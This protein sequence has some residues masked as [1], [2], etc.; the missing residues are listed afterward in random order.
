M[1]IARLL[2]LGGALLHL[3]LFGYVAAARFRYPWELDWLSGAILDHI[4]RLH[5]GLAQ[6]YTAPSVNWISYPYPPLHYWVSGWMMRI[7]PGFQGLRLLSILCTLIIAGWVWRLSRSHGGSRFWAT[8]ATGLFFAGYSLTDYWYDLERCDMLA[9]A[10]LGIGTVVLTESTTAVGA[11]ITGVLFALACLTKQTALIALVLVP[12][13]LLLRGEGRRVL[14]LLGAA[15]AVLVPA[16]LFINIRTHGW[17][18]FYAVHMIR[19][20]G[21]EP[22]LL[23]MFVTQDLGRALLLTVATIA[24]LMT[25]F[26]KPTAFG[27]MLAAGF[28]A[29]LWGRLHMGGWANV[30]MFWIPF[31]CVAFAVV[32]TRIEALLIGHP[33]AMRASALLAG[34]VM[35]QFA[36]MAFDPENQVP[37]ANRAMWAAKFVDKVHQLEREGEVLVVGRG[38]VTTPRHFHHNALLDV[39]RIP[40]QTFP[41]DLVDAIRAHRFGAIVLD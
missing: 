37:D 33:F 8:I 31:A 1:R 12:G 40:G 35:A 4:E 29:A 27:G 24:A 23:F 19:V 16:V 25:Q 30:L 36:L 2:A 41:A 26:R 10:L 22:R 32:A 5:Q 6:L 20:H 9:L 17:F 21:I 28:I 34:L 39:L 14:A 7:L 18:L 13:A 3:G 15:A 11:A 38:H